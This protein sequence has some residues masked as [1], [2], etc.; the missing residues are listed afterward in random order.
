MTSVILSDHSSARSFDIGFDGNRSF[1]P[2]FHATFW[3]GI[4]KVKIRYIGE[5]S[6]TEAL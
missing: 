4:N 5:I 3:L 1:R 2:I 6:N